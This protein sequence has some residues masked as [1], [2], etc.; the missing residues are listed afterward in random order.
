M[1]LL[2]GDNLETASLGGALAMQAVPTD[3]VNV[4]AGSGR[5]SVILNHLDHAVSTE[6][7]DIQREHGETDTL[8][9]CPVKVCLFWPR[10]TWPW[11]G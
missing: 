9:C 1:S 8:V 6:L 2:C 7:R 3:R 11:P 4:G 5:S 10:Y